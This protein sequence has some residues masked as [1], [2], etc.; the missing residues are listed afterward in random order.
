[1]KHVPQTVAVQYRAQGSDSFVQLVEERSVSPSGPTIIETSFPPA[2]CETRVV[3]SGLPS[4]NR[5]GIYAIEHLKLNMPAPG[6][7]FADPKS[8]LSAIAHWLLGALD[9]ADEV[10][11]A[12]AIG[13]LR[14]W[15]LSTASLSVTMLF[16]DM[17]LRLEIQD[18]SHQRNRIA[19]LAV[20]QG[21]LL[22]EGISAYH[23][24][25]SQRLAHECDKIAFGD[26]RRVA[27]IFESSVCSTGV[28]VEDGGLVVRTRETS[29]QYAAVNCGI[30]SGKA[31][32]K[33]RLDTD[34]Q[35]DE[36]TCFGA[37]ILPVTVSGY[38]SSPNL[39]MLRGYN[40][41]LYA[42]GHKL[43][44]TIGKVHPGD[45]VQVD[46]DMGEGTLA[47]KINGTDY[48]V[49]FTDLAGHE[50]HPAVSFYGSG[51]VITLLGVTK[52]DCT[53][54][55]PADIEP[56]FLSSMREYHFSVGY[57]TLGK[58]NQLGYASNGGPS[59]SQPNASA[60]GSAPI[61]IN[62]EAKQRCLSTHPPSHGDAYVIYDLAGAYHTISGGVAFNDDTRNEFLENGGV[63]LVFQIVGDDK[64]LWQSKPMSDTCLVEQFE[65]DIRKVRMLELKVSCRGSNHCAHAVW[66][67]PC[68]HPVE[69]WTCSQC[70][71]LNKGSSDT[72]TVCRIGVRDEGSVSIQELSSEDAGSERTSQLCITRED[73]I[74]NLGSPG[75]LGTTIIRQID[76]LYRLQSE[77]PS[78]SFISTKQSAQFEEPFCRQPCKDVFS[79]L[80]TILQRFRVQCGDTNRSGKDARDGC[81]HILGIISANLESIS[82]H[83]VKDLSTELGVSTELVST[84]RRELETMANIRQE[85][86]NLGVNLAEDI[87][88][89]AARTIVSGI[90][91]LYPS[92]IEKLQLLLQLLQSYIDHPF[93]ATSSNYF[94]LT[95]VMEL[96]AAPGPDG[97]LTFMPFM[98]AE[99][100]EMAWFSAVNETI[101]LLM[102]LVVDSHRK[103]LAADADSS[104]NC[105][106]LSDV[107]IRLLK[108]YQL[109]LLS[110]AV[111]LTKTN[112]IENDP[113]N[114]KDLSYLRVMV[115]RRF[116][117]Q[118]AT[119]QF[120][121]LSLNAYRDLIDNI[122][123][124][125]AEESFVL[126]REA[127]VRQAS[128]RS[129]KIPLLS[130]VLPWFVSCLCLL[131]RQTWLA[132]SILPAVVRL[133]ET[134]DHYCSESQIVSKSAHRFQQL[135]AHQKARLIESQEIERAA[136]LERDPSFRSHTSKRLYNVF[137]QLYTGEKDHFEGQIGF[138]FEATSS[139]SIV[140]L[141]R[142]VNPTRHGGRLTREH[143][144]RLWEEGSQLLVAQV[145]VGGSSKKD[146][147][148]YAL[149]M[150]PAPAKIIQGKLYRLTTQEFAN[151]GDPWYK[152]ENLPDEEY[153]E[154]FI[155]I[156][157]DCYASGSV[158]FPGSQNMMGA[159]Y[160]VPTFM[161]QDET[162]L[163][164]LP[165]F[166][167][168]HGCLS[169]R[170]NTKR[171]LNSVCISHT[172]TSAYVKDSTDTWRT[173]LLRTAFLHGV[174]SVDFALKSSR[175]GGTVSGHIS[176]GIDWRHP[177]E[178]RR[179]DARLSAY[180]TFM[181]ET[182]TSI[183]W[184]PSIGAVWVKG[185]RY[186]YGPRLS[187]S[188]GDIFTVTIDY[189]LQLLSFAY[190]GESVGV[191]VGPQ[192]FRPLG[193]TIEGL[194]EVV[195]AGASLYGSQDVV[196]HSNCWPPSGWCRR[197]ASTVATVTATEWGSS[198]SPMGL[199][200]SGANVPLR[201]NDAL[202]AECARYPSN[203]QGT[204]SFTGLAPNAPSS[205]E[206]ESS[207]RKRVSGGRF[208]ST[209]GVN[210]RDP[211]FW[212][213]WTKDMTERGIV[214]LIMS[215]LE[216]HCP[217]RT[218]LSR[219]GRFPSCER[220]M[221]AALIMHA[222]FHVLQEVQAIAAG[223]GATTAGEVVG[224]D[225]F[226][227]HA[228]LTPSDD[229]I[230]V[231]KRILILRHWL[232]KARQE[233]R[234]RE[235]DDSS[236]TEKRE[237]EVVSDHSTQVPLQDN[238]AGS[239]RLSDD[240]NLEQSVVVPKTFDELVQQV[241]H[242]AEF[243]C[244]LAP[245]SEEAE[246]LK[247]DSQIALFNLAEKW[248]A[249]K[250]P[251]SL[252]PMLDRWKT[253][254]E[255]DS[256]KWSGIV[257]VLRAQHRWR[258]RRASIQVIAIPTSALTQSIIQQPTDSDDNDDIDGSDDGTVSKKYDYTDSFSAMMKACELYIRDGTGAPPEVL[259]LLIERRQRRSDSRLFGLQAM[260]TIISLLSYDSAIHNALIFLRPA[261]RGFTDSE[262][263]SRE[264]N[265]GQV[266]AET[267]RAT[268]RHHYLKGLEGCN[269]QTIESVQS[270]FCDLYAYLAQ[271]LGGGSGYSVADPQLKQTILCAW[272]LDFEPRDHQFLLD[273]GM[274]SKLQ[275]I[276]SISSVLREAVADNKCT[277]TNSAD[278][279][280]THS[281]PH[282]YSSINWH[283]LSEEFIQQG[284]LRSGYMTK[285][286]V[287]CLLRRAPH[288]ACPTEW[289]K[290]NELD[291]EGVKDAVPLTARHTASSLSLLY[292]D[293]LA[294]LQRKLL[295]PPARTPTSQ[296]LLFGAKITPATT[297]GAQGSTNPKPD[298]IS[299]V[300]MPALGETK[301]FTME[302][303]I[304]P[305]ELMGCQALR[306]DN[307]VGS[308]S[309]Y[310]EL[311][312][313][314]LQLSIPGNFPRER[315][316]RSFQFRTFEWT[317]FAVAYDSIK[318]SVELFVNG[319]LSEKMVFERVYGNINFRASRLG[320]WM[321]GVDAQGAALTNI[322]A[323]RK[324]KGSIAEVRIWR[325][326]RTGH[327]ILYDFQRSVPLVKPSTDLSSTKSHVFSNNLMGLWHA[328]EGEGI[329]V[330]D[331]A[332]VLKLATEGPEARGN[333]LTA[334]H[335]R[336]VPT[337]MP[338]FGNEIVD[339]LQPK[340][341]SR[342]IACIR[343]FQ[344]RI[345]SWLA[346][347]FDASVRLSKLICEHDE[348]AGIVKWSQLSRV[349]DDDDE[350]E[351]SD[352]DDAY[353]SEGQI[354][355]GKPAP[356]NSQPLDAAASQ[357]I[358]R[359]SACTDEQMIIRKQTRRC[360]WVVF[361]FLASTGISGA[362][363]RREGEA[364]SVAAFAKQKRK[365]RLQKTGSS[366][367][368]AVA[369]GLPS[370]EVSRPQGLSF[371]E[372]D[373]AARTAEAASDAAKTAATNRE[374]E[375]PVLQTLWFSKE[376]HRKVFE[377]LEKELIQGKELTEEAEGLTRA[378]RMLRSVSTPVQKRGASLR[379]YPSDVARGK[380]GFVNIHHAPSDLTGDVEVLEPLEVE[381]HMFGILLFLLSQ[382]QQSPAITYLVRP[383][384]LRSLLEMLRLA[385][386]RSQRVV[387]LLLRRI[388]CSGS[389]KPSDVGAILGSE[390]VLIDLLLDQV[391]E[392]VCSTAAPM[393]THAVNVP[394]S[395]ALVGT[396]VRDTTMASTESLSNPIGF[397]SGQISLVVASESVAL[398]R[399]LLMEKKWQ[400]GVADNLCNAIRNIAP[401]LARKKSGPPSPDIRVSPDPSDIRFRAAIIRAVGA[402]C[403][404]GSH[405]DC[406]RVGGKVAVAA[407][408]VNSTSDASADGS[409]Q[410]VSATL[411]EMNS[412]ASTVRV[413]FH[414]TSSEFDFDPSHNIQDVKLSAVSPTE[415]ICLPPTA[416]PL[417]M[418]MMPVILQLSSLDE[419]SALKEFDSLW[420]LQ[421]RSRALLALEA[422]LRHSLHVTKSFAH[423]TMAQK[424]LRFALTPISL[425]SFLSLPLL[426][427]RGR[428]ILCRLI[429]SATPLGE[430]M[431]QGLQD[432]TPP[433]LP[434]SDST[435]NSGTGGVEANDDPAEEE[436]EAHRVRRGFASTLA[437]MGFE[438]DLCMAALEHSRDDPNLAV[439]WLMGDGAATYQ[440]RQQAQRLAQATIAAHELADGAEGSPGL[441]LEAKASELQNISGMP[442]CL[443]FCALEL[444]NSDPN[445]A[446]EWLMEHGSNYAEKFDSL[447][448]LT[449]SFSAAR[450]VVLEDRAAMEEIDQPD[451]LVTTSDRRDAIAAEYLGSA[452]LSRS[453]E[454]SY[455]PNVDA[456][457]VT[458]API[459][460]P[461]PAKASSGVAA[462]RDASMTAFS[463][464]DP[465]YLTPNVLL[466]VTSDIGPVQRLATSGRTGIYR[467]YSPDD[468][469][470][471]T[472]LN[473]ESGAYEDEWHF[474][475]DL[476]RIVKIY[477]EPLE[478]V[479]S[480]HRV[481]LRTENALSTYYARR[482]ITAL[483]C[484]FDSAGG[485]I[486][487]ASRINSDGAQALEDKPP[488]LSS[489]FSSEILSVVGGPRQFVSLLKM[490]AASEMTSTQ[491]T[492]AD[493]KNSTAIGTMAGGNNTPIVDSSDH[494]ASLLASLQ[495]ITLR[496]LR[497]EAHTEKFEHSKVTSSSP[498]PKR[499]QTSAHCG[500]VS[501]SISEHP[502][503]PEILEYGEEDD[504][505]EA[506]NRAIAMS[507]ES[508][509]LPPA[510]VPDITQDAVD[511]GWLNEESKSEDISG[512]R[513]RRTRQPSDTEAQEVASAY[514]G[515]GIDDHDGLLSSVLVKECVSHFVES[516]RMAGDG[517]GEAAV[518]EFQS[519]HPYFGRCEYARAV[520]IDSSYR[521]LRIVFDHR[522]RL[523]PK[524]KLT[525][526]ADPECE[527]RIGVVDNAM[528]TSGHLLPDLIIHSHQF[529]FRFTASEE[530]V[531]KDNGYGYRFQVK[532][533]ASI[534]WSKESEVLA[535]PSLEWACW[536]L[537]LLLNDAT[538]LVA[539]GAVH[540]R[541]IY[542]ALVRYLRSPGAPF[543]GRVVR[544]LQQLLHH[545]ELFPADEVP[546][547]DALESISRLAVTRAEVDRAS[548]KV[549]LSAHLL[550]LV[551]LSMVIT[552]ASSVFD[553]KLSGLGAEPASHLTTPFELPVPFERKRV[554]DSLNDVS[555]LTRFLLG[556]TARLPQHVLVAIW[557]EM[558]GSSTVIET[559]HPYTPGVS[560]SGHLGFDAAQALRITFD[561]RCSLAPGQ[562]QTMSRLEL[563]SFML[564]PRD[565][566]TG[567]IVKEI[568][569]NRT[570]AGEGGWPEA[571][572]SHDGNNLEYKFYAD[573]NAGAHFGFAATVNALNIP[574][575]KQIA[576]ATVDDMEKLLQKL[577]RMQADSPSG[578]DKWT[579]EMDL[580]L[581]DWVNNHVEPA[582]SLPSST[583]ATTK[584]SVDL[585]PS[586]IKLNQ[587]LDGLRCSQLLG[588][589]LESLQ[590]RFAL[591]KFLN[592]SLQHCLSLLDLRDTKSPWTIAHRLRQLSHCI[593][594]DVKSALV[595]AAIEATNVAGET[596]GSNSQQQTARI[597]LDRMQALESRDDREVEPSVS[598]CFFAQAFRQLNQVDPALLRRQIDSK[599]RLFSVK[600]RGEEGVDWGGVYR[601]GATSMVDD[602]FSP[603]FS[604]FVLCPN[605]QHDTGNNRGMYLPN[606]KCTSP[607]AMQM[608]AF[609]GQLLGISLRTHGD[610][611]FML[612]SLVWKQLLGQTL[613][614]SD[615]E[616]TD[617]MFI[618]MLDG[619]ANCQNDGISTEEEFATAFA[620]LEL[621][622]T[623]SSCTGEEIE[624][625]PGGRHLTVGF[626]NR[627]EYCRLA[628]RAR[629]DE[630]SAQ[631]AAMA[632]GF[633]TLFPRRVL[634]LLTWQEL[635]ILTC[636][637]PK[638]DLDLW[639]RHTRYDGY[640][641]DDP[642][643]LLFWEAL[644]EFSDEQRADFVR[645]AWG[646][647]RLPRGKWPQ[648]FKLSK[649]GGR[650]ATRSLP[651]AHT[652]FFSVE[653]PPYTSRETMRS[654]LLATITFGLGGILMA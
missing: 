394:S 226:L 82:S 128:V 415:E 580:Q 6:S 258:A 174:H 238:T 209:E 425:S 575:E 266:V 145:T 257:D 571:A 386:P 387:K 561:S 77:R 134:V 29:Y 354:G 345:R 460:A 577:L 55:G 142:S 555:E 76:D 36:M 435:N 339:N 319:V 193:T 430:T 477:D 489:S 204:G 441:T 222:P 581:V 591:L 99:T 81:V 582:A 589:S 278:G 636:G 176:V 360:A 447:D 450:T 212:G 51:K 586:D 519:L 192:E 381:T 118:E 516:T 144:I 352:S 501:E 237:S 287:I 643:V 574:K 533:M 474:P 106:G 368:V 549:F 400:Q 329:C 336:W 131:R 98:A 194:P 530:N 483:L 255:A 343:S 35:D 611:P 337:S 568:R 285:R 210:Q 521:C 596:S 570:Y 111:E 23:Q 522:C 275:E 509:Q 249:Q 627:L 284:L 409:G 439:E 588:L 67:D 553:R 486:G 391:A 166:V 53:S 342:V 433:A 90:S 108:T 524:A 478:G 461:G 96:L 620:G 353:L 89:S 112:S 560:L 634:T 543:K 150:L 356:R 49:V 350:L 359:W 528:T 280:L 513:M 367:N 422:L 624:L 480:I 335:C 377:V 565:D 645:F 648:P 384:M 554:R 622:F 438:F 198:E 163:A 498:S 41:N 86:D 143:T 395:S 646:R 161:V 181:G 225:F 227:A 389:I 264:L 244:K 373:V 83:D 499:D 497:E 399:R 158:G 252:Q 370:A 175:A 178:L 56:I 232:I 469:V 299:Y 605:G 221:C 113:A 535:S 211:S 19:A 269:R 463:P 527:D 363:E 592:L 138:Q 467:R 594:F 629:L 518:Q 15:A 324:F 297:R 341:W 455:A 495:A 123:G 115:Q 32:W 404:L 453:A 289:W 538:E 326:S 534:R 157:R 160:G 393:P 271:L 61:H 548:G 184:M 470:L 132:R 148:G 508:A 256:S 139:F 84:L 551:E 215:W 361:R 250:T 344:R 396:A 311:I 325:V 24:E 94:V 122:V 436:T 170:F 182:A 484:A 4:S 468:G 38:D 637:S 650:D 338:V 268:V 196:Q 457:A 382:S 517:A 46:V 449:D 612:P 156:L 124:F 307:G 187:V 290:K 263:E 281:S 168:P 493:G 173:C 149:E 585:Q 39:W 606:P 416:V 164:S 475:R 434:A 506:L 308:G 601:E 597:T 346:K 621:R 117:V 234:A 91:V 3:L 205:V 609:V 180:E 626:H 137:H 114:P 613:T 303:W 54:S 47:Y 628:E 216:K 641:E 116:Q 375:E 85:S 557:L 456:M 364:K 25:K 481:A 191:A 298:D 398:L 44:R 511:A 121:F 583:P 584:H 388:C 214:Q 5:N 71:F 231:W 366:G 253:L 224:A 246:R 492:E 563:A 295:G 43:S 294:G 127:A 119:I 642:T 424:L 526:Y 305:T 267:F 12:E 380:S 87:E 333:N 515:G 437:A 587:T 510:P 306:C 242:R 473:T 544:L 440:E 552:S 135:E 531:T 202:Q 402:L 162:P 603:H 125:Q 451:P 417:T 414:P 503:V 33:F 405:S 276:F 185:K 13:A 57:G 547:L 102:K 608:F 340:E 446:M 331:S 649:K 259:A 654:M 260:K 169:L 421:I 639:Q 578:G 598:E 502:V 288:Y 109:Y 490:V 318:R 525:F 220:W 520:S 14:A 73:Y 313:R 200:Q 154:S 270:A 79:L 542:G 195:T 171:K 536:V 504:D 110:E 321:S 576:R 300:E 615:L 572:I 312:G 631:V 247:G 10:M 248:S 327:D 458:L 279:A 487:N 556:Q 471:V 408:G 159:A 59:A 30:S 539:H 251:P 208:D 296:A 619:I 129:Y 564:V 635:E 97:I 523:G 485:S 292:A 541:K 558:Y 136:T 569:S 348:R 397:R 644:A 254:G 494:P 322:S 219:L 223:A 347:Q 593:F 452:A 362:Y 640:S 559:S 20:E 599:G 60:T 579:H 378:Q 365:Q 31:S 152:K 229:L 52:W 616:G 293:M 203:D 50:V 476:R 625:V 462:S 63:S 140:A 217:D 651:V 213:N 206:N 633:A 11:A 283:P 532:P 27:A 428:M 45:I 70:D 243:L 66:V 167:P 65:V 2:T 496:M 282:E 330:Y 540:N 78:A 147:L 454:L 647:S 37:A 7:L 188:V 189:D 459:L 590:L 314:H 1:M 92:A 197:G 442:Y 133:L 199:D 277:H 101:G 600:F 69:E 26:V 630:C 472:F 419:T 64:L 230:L 72:C 48:G 302:M 28:I 17:L 383:H 610:F 349:D 546:E 317:H 403:V 207:L 16:V 309:V 420:R 130:E 291:L 239:K 545:S 357:L 179:S 401:I 444:S 466:T 573:E 18:E 21:R 236:P 618:Q 390:S 235:A 8:T 427:E 407:Q 328:T 406:V 107:A 323:Q 595:E 100:E 22:C 265:D 141:G 62:G 443:A 240:I 172:G 426:Q 385:S 491:H 228:D 607:V 507:I 355:G 429:E 332:P 445:R 432:P 218:F 358:S 464:L 304:Y 602:L 146:A 93:E 286:D 566:G 418:D 423:D 431:F 529:W 512:Y 550:Q 261:M 410:S 183:G 482:A 320:C 186:D 310:L 88:K 614:R 74:Q 413:V 42:R 105:D 652:C 75:E 500:G 126:S 245:P 505:D 562:G 315:L 262:K 392:S 412:Q 272:S 151:G 155:K 376:F 623:A 379:Q 488:S 567:E 316:F 653:L 604:L 273:T 479:E 9:V 190:N 274:L 241:I 448:L 104:P 103:Q 34:T 165:R 372:E 233:Y 153:D 95:S 632:R 301:D 120:C 617:A 40:G 177:L 465:D 638:I 68:L 80:L 369:T 537:E 334:S 58:G 374:L 371:T 514:L 351:L 411:I 201:W